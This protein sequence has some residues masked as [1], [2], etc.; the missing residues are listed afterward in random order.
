MPIPPS[1]NPMVYVTI[2]A[3]MN[4]HLLWYKG[5][6][7]GVQIMCLELQLLRA[8]AI[9]HAQVIRTIRVVEIV[10]MDTCL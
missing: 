8:I 1:I 9:P 7:V 2:S 4:M 10:Y 6:I 5:Q 3:W